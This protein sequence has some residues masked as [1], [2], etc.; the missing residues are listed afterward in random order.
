MKQFNMYSMT[1]K[2][3]E[4]CKSLIKMI[5]AEVELF[6]NEQTGQVFTEGGMYAADYKDT[7]DGC[8]VAC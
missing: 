8:G 1:G 3:E 4:D 7:E 2:T 6:V 5:D